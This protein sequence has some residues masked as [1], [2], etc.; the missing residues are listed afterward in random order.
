MDEPKPNFFHSTTIPTAG[1]CHFFMIAVKFNDSIIIHYH[2]AFA[3]N[4]PKGSLGLFHPAV[5]MLAIAAT[6]AT[7]M[8]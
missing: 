6:L 3:P 7:P 2:T 5:D 8:N 4:L 1:Q